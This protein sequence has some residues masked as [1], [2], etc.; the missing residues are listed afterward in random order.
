MKSDETKSSCNDGSRKRPDS[1][2]QLANRVER[3]YWARREMARRLQN[4][5]MYW[6][7]ALVSLAL[8]ASLAGVA[9][10]REP[11]LYG[12][13]GDVAMLIL[14]IFSLVASLMVATSSYAERARLAFENY[15]TL[16]RLST[17]L[18]AAVSVTQLSARAS[19]RLYEKFDQR[20][21]DIL[22]TSNNH[23]PADF[24]KVIEL[25]W[26]LPATECS[27]R[28]R[29][30]NVDYLKLWQICTRRIQQLATL[31]MTMLPIALIAVAIGLIL[32]T[33]VWLVVAA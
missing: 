24:I 9:Q 18:E 23:E 30:N 4:R 22:D 31:T 2:R 20:Y 7:V 3:T 26:A 29:P 5:G 27:K 15:R 14:G 12:A 25:R 19:R 1:L 17:E 6:N 33:I 13:N 8:S 28:N 16:Q 32:P 21:Q 10:L 11:N